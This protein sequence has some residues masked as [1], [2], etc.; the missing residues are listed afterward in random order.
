LRLFSY[1]DIMRLLRDS[2]QITDTHSLE[3]IYSVTMFRAQLL[4]EEQRRLYDVWTAAAGAQSMPSKASF[5]PR[6][7][8][9]L[10][11]FI[12]L[13]DVQSGQAGRVRVA[14]SAL[15]DVFGGDP[16]MCLRQ[17]SASGAVETI[18]RVAKDGRPACGVAPK[19]LGNGATGVR[20]WLRLPL[21]EDGDVQA[22]I[23]LDIALCGARAPQWALAQMTAS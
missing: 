21:G 5:Q 11:P 18:V 23:G 6:A 7:F 10:L 4:L 13:I 9:P 19:L 8:G 12:S 22:V 14:G 2:V 1:F 16:E 3:G 20:F 17:I 15:R